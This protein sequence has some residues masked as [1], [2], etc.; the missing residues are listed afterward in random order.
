MNT[1]ETKTIANYVVENIK[2][3]EV[4]KKYKINYSLNGDLNLIQ[5]CKP[6]KINYIALLE[7]LKQVDQKISYFKN[8]D[9]WSLDFLVDYII[10]IHHDYT[11]DR[12]PIIINLAYSVSESHAEKHPVLK[13]IY[14]LYVDFSIQLISHM[15][16]E[17]VHLFPEIKNF[18]NNNNNNYTIGLQEKLEK[19]I[20]DHLNICSKIIDINELTKGFTYPDFKCKTLAAL[21]Y[22]LKNFEE[23]FQKHLHLENN[24]LFPKVHTLLLKTNKAS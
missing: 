3:A 18:L 17:E 14:K 4:F 12:I 10:K 1:L 15:K 11:E 22:T 24:I 8:Y 2:T 13:R 16:Q 21:F 23:E 9:S 19:A 6:H 7:E 20:Q 5:A